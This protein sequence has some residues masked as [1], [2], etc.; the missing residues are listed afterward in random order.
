MFPKSDSRHL[1]EIQL[2]IRDEIKTNPNSTRRG[3]AVS[4]HIGYH[5]ENEDARQ[6][7]CNAYCLSGRSQSTRP[8]WME[9][10]RL[11]RLFAELG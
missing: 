2:V 8:L 9:E 11:H 10:T 7:S 6:E 5:K 1:D 3:L 4:M